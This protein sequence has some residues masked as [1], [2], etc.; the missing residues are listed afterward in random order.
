MASRTENIRETMRF[1]FYEEL[2]TSS[3]SGDH[4]LRFGLPYIVE[5]IKECNYFITY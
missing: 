3:F 4:A 5:V 2:C 1:W